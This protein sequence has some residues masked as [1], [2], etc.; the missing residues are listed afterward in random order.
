[1][2]KN[3]IL[4]ISLLL[5]TIIYLNKLFFFEH[6]VCFKEINR[7]SYSNKNVCP[8]GFT[9]IDNRN[10]L[11]SILNCDS[12][13]IYDRDT[14]IPLK[15]VMDNDSIKMSEYMYKNSVATIELLNGKNL[16]FLHYNYLITYGIQVHKIYYSLYN[17]FLKDDSPWNKAYTEFKNLLCIRYQNNKTNFDLDYVI[18]DGYIYLYQIPKCYNIRPYYGP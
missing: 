3:N 10:Q 6:S 9:F 4:L 1:M 7:C 18:G 13:I 5:F 15:T 8:S 12:D 16:D 2:G 14:L 11:M 17:T